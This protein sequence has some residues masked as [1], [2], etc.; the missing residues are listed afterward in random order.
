MDYF[1][2]YKD[3]WK[4][5]EIREISKYRYY[6]SIKSFVFEKETIKDLNEEAILHDEMRWYIK[7]KTVSK[8]W[9]EKEQWKIFLR[10]EFFMKDMLDLDK[11]NENFFK[12]AEEIRDKANRDREKM[13]EQ[14]DKT[15]EKEDKE[16]NE[17]WYEY[18]SEHAVKT[19]IPVTQ[20]TL[21]KCEF[22]DRQSWKFLNVLAW[23]PEEFIKYSSEV[24][25][26]WWKLTEDE[27]KVLISSERWKWYDYEVSFLWWICLRHYHRVDPEYLLELDKKKAKW[28]EQNKIKDI[29]WDDEYL[30][31]LIETLEPWELLIITR[32]DDKRIFKGKG[33]KG[34]PNWIWKWVNNNWDVFGWEFVDW[35][36]SWKWYVQLEDWSKFEWTRNNWILNAEWL[37][38]KKLTF[39]LEALDY[40]VMPEKLVIQRNED[41]WLSVFKI[42][43]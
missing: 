22:F 6:P 34:I 28:D 8:Y 14:F 19:V 38:G 10:E 35:T 37:E 33:T 39:H 3:L 24:W 31:N 30:Q 41:W 32:T 15:D 17:I 7:V 13:L 18:D 9:E 42:Q 5:T 21:P 27:Y 36:A 4:K 23:K 26:N 1:Y 12:E 43:K 20:E 16:E 2:T 29:A 40:N 11:E 25:A